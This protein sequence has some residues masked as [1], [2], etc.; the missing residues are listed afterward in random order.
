MC[1]KTV[2]NLKPIEVGTGYKVF[3][4]YNRCL[5]SL[6][7]EV[8][9][10]TGEWLTAVDKEKG[11]SESQPGFHIYKTRAVARKAWGFVDR[12]WDKYKGRRFEVRKVIYKDATKSGTGDGGFVV[13]APVVIAN[14]MYILDTKGRM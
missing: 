9:M 12:N 8:P 3:V 4:V 14:K 1:M 7:K 6:C 11:H 2:L 10:P 13:N 5:T